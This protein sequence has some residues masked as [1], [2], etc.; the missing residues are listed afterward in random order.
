MNSL[1]IYD[2]NFGNTKLVAEKIEETIG[3]G[4]RAV[5]VDKLQPKD[6]EAAEL[7]IV[8][9]PI[10]G[11]RP[12]EKINIFLNSLKPGQLKEKKAASFDTRIN[13]FFHGDACQK[14]SKVLK[15]AGAEIIDKPHWFFVK[16]KSG[17]LTEGELEKSAVWANTLRQNST[18]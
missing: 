7:L 4:C 8:G 1:V 5:H 16:G 3:Q 18:I 11:W 6:L 15:N 13:V 2:S 12:T 10:I 17:P 14:I 9:C